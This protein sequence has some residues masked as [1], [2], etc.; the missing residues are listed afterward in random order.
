MAQ[1]KQNAAA[2]QSAVIP[3]AE[4][5]FKKYKKAVIGCLVA[6]VVVVGGFFAYK[7]LYQ[8]PREDKAQ[9]LLAQGQALAAQ[10]KYDEALK[11]EGKFPGLLKLINNY[12]GTDAAN[13]AKAQAGFCYAQQG[14]YKEAVAQLESFSPAGD[15]SLTPAALGA[16][17]N[18]Y[19]GVGQIDKAIATYQDAAERA[20]NEILSP[21]FLVKAGELLE[22][23]KK[24][25]EAVSVYKS[26]KEKYPRCQ[27]SVAQ[28]QQDGSVGAAMIDVFIERA[29]K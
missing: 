24:Y 18:A 12:S 3:Q 20:D 1:T 15:N 17:A 10:Q 2:Q 6:V 8:Q 7:Y 22:T 5:F 21:L 25:P 11:G 16:L 9:A 4:A 23:Q 14:K 19:A 26:V 13:A 29:T 27:Y 28:Q